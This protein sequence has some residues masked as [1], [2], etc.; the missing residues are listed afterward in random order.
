MNNPTTILVPTKLERI[1]AD[2]IKSLALAGYTNKPLMVTPEGMVSCHPQ[3]YLTLR[4]DSPWI[5]DSDSP[6][7]ML[8]AK[9][10]HAYINV[11]GV[12]VPVP[13]KYIT[14]AYVITLSPEEE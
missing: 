11:D 3:Y 12:I 14:G 5:A 7:L 2:E 8:S 9:G 1:S 10:L 13:V 6:Y 4:E